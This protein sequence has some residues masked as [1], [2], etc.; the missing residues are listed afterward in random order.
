MCCTEL[1]FGHVPHHVQ[2][3]ALRPKSTCTTDIPR[4]PEPS[5]STA[6]ARH[7][8]DRHQTRI[9]CPTRTMQQGKTRKTRPHRALLTDS[10]PTL[11]LDSGRFETMHGLMI[12]N[13]HV[14]NMNQSLMNKS[15]ATTIWGTS[16]HKFIKLWFMLA[17]R[18]FV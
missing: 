13:N 3:V 18:L 15:V 12:H 16:R 17:T 5:S 2:D 9:P 8:T 10:L 7:P 1:S 11:C 14:A 4:L 6:T